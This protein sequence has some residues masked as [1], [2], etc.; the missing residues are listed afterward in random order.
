MIQFIS[1]EKEKVRIRSSERISVMS[2][3]MEKFIRE[4]PRDPEIVELFLQRSR[5][6]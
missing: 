4:L 2:N 3:E 6:H 1:S 5:T